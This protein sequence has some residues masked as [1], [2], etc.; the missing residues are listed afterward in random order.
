MIIK[1]NV[2]INNINYDPEIVDYGWRMQISSL[3]VDAGQLYCIS[4]ANNGVYIAAGENGI[5]LYS[6]DANTWNKSTTPEGY[7]STI[8]GITYD[9]ISN[10][11]VLVGGSSVL[12]TNDPT[13]GWNI[14]TLDNAPGLTPVICVHSGDI[15]TYVTGGDSGIIYYTTDLS[16]ENWNSIILTSDAGNLSIRFLIYANGY[17]IVIGRDGYIAYTR[18]LTLN[19][20]YYQIQPIVNLQCIC[21]NED[22]N[23][24][25]VVGDDGVI[26]YTSDITSPLLWESSDSGIYTSIQSVVYDSNLKLYAAVSVDGDIIL[27]DDLTKQW[28]KSVMDTVSNLQYIIY[29]KYEDIFLIAGNGMIVKG[30]SPIYIT[31]TKIID[32][33]LRAKYPTGS[34]LT[35]TIE[36]N[37]YNYLGFGS[38]SMSYDSTTGDY[39]YL[40]TS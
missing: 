38:W 30:I 11:Y 33:D 9:S 23:E 6:T 22:K 12:Y 2:A 27:S 37:P 28:Y 16:S 21:F 8:D 25:V 29:D 7:T 10:T 36:N 24:Y 35:T 39:T 3:T 31:R 1:M 20:T 32:D 5:I 26:L 19:W 13:S 17:Y 34:T 14:K 40:R 18:D 4:P 15:T